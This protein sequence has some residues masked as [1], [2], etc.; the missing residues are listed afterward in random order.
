MAEYAT[1]ED[2]ETAKEDRASR[3]Q[4]RKAHSDREAEEKEK[5]E[6]Q[7]FRRGDGVAQFTREHFVSI[8]EIF[9]ISGPRPLEWTKP[10]QITVSYKG[11]PQTIIEPH[12]VSFVGGTATDEQYRDAEKYIA[13]HWGGK[14]FI[15]M[16]PNTSREFR[17]KSLAYAQVYGNKLVDENNDHPALALTNAELARLP[18]LCSEIRARHP[19]APPDRPADRNRQQPPQ[20]EPA[21]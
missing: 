21:S 6:Q 10:D 1:A 15:S 11:G 14:S 18:A 16:N 3:E 5:Y 12:R 7:F 4:F 9:E 19:D 20:P 8:R 13:K 17:L 2:Y